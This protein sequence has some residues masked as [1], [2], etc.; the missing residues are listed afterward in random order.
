LLE[1]GLETVVL[2]AGASVGAAPLAWGHVP[3]FSPWRYNIDRAARAL[4]ER[5]GWR[6]PDAETFPT[7]RDLVEDYLA[8]LARLPELAPRLRLNTR[9]TGVARLHAG[10]V[11]DAEREEQPFELWFENAEGNEGRLLARAIIVASGT[12]GNPSPAGASG[13]PAIGEWEAADRIRYGMPDVLGD[14]RAR[15]AGQRVLVVGSGHSA[16]GTLID[17]AA[18]AEQAPGTAVLWANPG[19]RPSGHD[20]GNSAV[21]VREVCCR[22]IGCMVVETPSPN[23]RPSP[24]GGWFREDRRE[25]SDRWSEARSGVVEEGCANTSPARKGFQTIR[26]SGVSARCSA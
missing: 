25:G 3:M 1:R 16:I 13:L 2:E 20:H 12:W 26:S 11:R 6:A 9:V 7:G 19:R 17:L 10:K 4:L 23:P 15:Y 14:D 8:P 5:H 18:L 24:D 21:E 22:T